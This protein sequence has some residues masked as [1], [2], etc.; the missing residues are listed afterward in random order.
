MILEVTAVA[1]LSATTPKTPGVSEVADDI[2]DRTTTGA[3]CLYG[4]N[5]ASWKRSD[6]RSQL[7]T[8]ERDPT[9]ACPYEGSVPVAK[10][11][12]AIAH[13]FLNA[14]PMGTPM[15]DVGAEPDGHIAFDW[16]GEPNHTI[17]VSVSPEG[18]LYYAA[19]I[20]R[21]SSHGSEFFLGDVP[22]IILDLIHRVLPDRS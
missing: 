21:N 19:L 20:G 11:T 5:E 22:R 8:I 1:L 2:R 16:R 18:Y 9:G 12:I 13:S 17:S 15:P 7:V 14:L 4:T 6:A 3:N 10:E